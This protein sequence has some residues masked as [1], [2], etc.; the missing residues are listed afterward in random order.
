MG[1]TNTGLR[2]KY[3]TVP[4]LPRTISNI[5]P[6]KIYTTIQDLYT[7]EQSREQSPH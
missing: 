3:S 1:L 7:P 5:S 2:K 6:L 4:Y